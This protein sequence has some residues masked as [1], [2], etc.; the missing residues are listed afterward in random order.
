MIAFIQPFSIN[1]AGGGA[2]IL[3]SLVSGAPLPYKSIATAARYYK[4][5][6]DQCEIHLPMRPDLGRMENGRAGRYLGV[7]RLE[8]LLAT[9]F[10]S[11][12]G[13]ALTEIGATAVHTI[14]HG[15]DFWYAYEVAN[16]LGISYFM[17]V[18][19]D[20]TYNL[21]GDPNLPFAMKK[22]AEVWREADGC[23]VISE[24]MGE[25][26]AR[27][28]GQREYKVVTDGLIKVGDRPREPSSG[29]FRVYMMGLM[30]LSYERTVLSLMQAL[31]QLDD[32]D[33]KREVSFT[34]RGGLS[35]DITGADDML[36]VL[37]WGSQADIEHDLVSAD[38]LYLPLP[39]GPNHK[40]FSKFSLS[41]K[42]VTY[43]GTGIPILYHGPRDAAAAH[44]LRDHDAAICVYSDDPKELSKALQTSDERKMEVAGNA[45]HLARS[46]FML[47]DIL[48]DFW[49]MVYP[50][51]LVSTELNVS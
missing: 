30:H 13:N 29:T 9:N 33:S 36:V 43:L 31:R 50:G 25:E 21:E 18:H 46:K 35:F 15:L 47:S 28:Y 2:K 49:E 17:S 3:R 39:I 51:R 22:L 6:A 8:R 4:K 26:Y 42:L 12:L 38:L 48:T 20:M 5:D 16:E 10:K 27:R 34:T 37:P 44:L 23:T 14:P 19:D 24:Q 7:S 1:G 32:L 11:R 41:T 45:L 40:S